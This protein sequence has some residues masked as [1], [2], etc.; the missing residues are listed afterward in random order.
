MAAMADIEKA[1]SKQLVVGSWLASL[2][3][4]S[5]PSELEIC[6]ILH[7]VHEVGEILNSLIEAGQVM[8]APKV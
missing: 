2:D 5:S 1:H 7:I 8:E 3:K 4:S 6:G